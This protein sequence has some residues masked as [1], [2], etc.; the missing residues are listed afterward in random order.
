MRGTATLPHGTGKPVRVCAFAEG[1]D[2]EAALAAGASVS[3]LQDVFVHASPLQ[4]LTWR[5]SYRVPGHRC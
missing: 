3:L 5:L 1:A 4:A 2:A